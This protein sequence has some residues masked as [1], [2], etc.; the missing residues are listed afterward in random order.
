MK[1]RILSVFMAICLMLTLLPVSAFAADA[2]GS[3]NY[4]T[5]NYDNNGL[6][7]RKITVHVYVDNEL[8][9]T[10]NIDDA[11]LA[12]QGITISLTQAYSSQYDIETVAKENG[13]GNFYSGDS[14]RD[15]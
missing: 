14:N 13:S 10:V 4:V 2:T 7:Q 3:N 5:V 11:K 9:D 12:E 15:S 1:K 8:V 6:Y